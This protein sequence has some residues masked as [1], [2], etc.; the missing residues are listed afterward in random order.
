MVDMEVN[1]TNR[2]AQDKNEAASSEAAAN[3][4]ENLFRFNELPE[5][6]KDLGYSWRPISVYGA[7][8]HFADYL[9]RNGARAFEVDVYATGDSVFRN[10]VIQL[11]ATGEG[12]FAEDI[13]I[14]FNRDKGRQLLFSRST[15]AIKPV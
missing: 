4:R 12:H 7:L 1:M 5:I 3:S 13:S 9:I 8:E 15:I 2:D 10:I 6:R 11:P 14:Q